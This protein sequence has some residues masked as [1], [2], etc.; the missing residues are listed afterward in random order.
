MN[1]IR[2]WLFISLFISLVSGLIVI[3]FT[4]DAGTIE[5]LAEIR[6]EYII[7]AACVH[8]LTYVIWGLR[9]HSLCKAL[10]YNVGYMKS[11]EIVTSGTLAASI[12]PS[13]LGGEPLRIHLLHGENIPLGKATAV[14]LGERLLDGILILTLAP[15]SIYIIRGVLED[16][17][18][19]AMF[20]FAEAG[21]IFILFLTLYAM[22]RPEP[23]RKVV[24][25][26]VHKL[27]PVLG[28][29]TDE[30]LEKIIARVDSELE[31]FHDSISVLLNEGRRGLA[32]G[33]FLTIA[34]WFVDFSM[35]YVILVGLNQNPSPILVFAS[36]VIIMILIVIPATPG[37]SGIAEFA[38]TTA[39]SLFTASSVLG[40]AVIAWRAFTFYMN[41][42]VG[43]FV[44][45][46][47]L[48]DADFIKKYLN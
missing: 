18:F 22:W 2:K 40:I 26:F 16:S 28:K 44:S 46:K 11:I 41:I 36:Q 35:L 48:K 33:I 24:Y 17:V 39:F 1:N 6:P 47:I 43:G 3:L 31:H 45:F 4:F 25:F 13:S 29:K 30:A 32:L 20:L 9:T 8:A 14:V 10:G 7:A 27:A 38:G 5:A 42:L 34:F 37:A 21:L 19:D 12:T 15:I 23:T